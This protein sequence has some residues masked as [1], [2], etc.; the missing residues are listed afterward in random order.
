MKLYEH[1]LNMPIS[2]YYCFNVNDPILSYLSYLRLMRFL[3]FELNSYL[4][5]M[6]QS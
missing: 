2:I 4:P 3:L 5:V 6:G 1:M